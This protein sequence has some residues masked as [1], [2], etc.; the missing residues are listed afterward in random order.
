MLRTWLSRIPQMILVLVALALMART[1]RFFTPQTLATIL[2]VGSI[3]GVLAAGQAF[4]LIAGGFDLSQGAIMGLSAASAAMLLRAGV[5]PLAAAAATLMLGGSLGALNGLCVATL[6]TNPFV[7]TLSTQMIFRGATFVALS[8]QQIGGL[9]AY[10]RLSAGPE[11]G[12]AKFALRAFLF[13]G[14]TVLAWLTLRQ[15][16][17]GQHVYAVGGNAEAARLAGVRTGRIR[18]LTFALSGLA[19]ALGAILL[20][21]WVR[22]AKPDTG[23]G[24]ELQSI[25]ACVIGGVSLQGGA[26]SVLG[27]AAGCML[28]QALDNLI[29]RSGFPDEYRT[30]V[31]GGVI[32][33]FAAADALGRRAERR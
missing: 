16:V 22:T 15:T 21:S 31:V 2:Q 4:V 14:V 18:V 20:L 30:L 26:G 5:T 17:F 8:G 19:G 3:V 32:L 6:R 24:Y 11:L 33:T 13:L 27:A 28:L 10:D 7:T 25:A 1:E 23:A 9:V 29:T 12:G